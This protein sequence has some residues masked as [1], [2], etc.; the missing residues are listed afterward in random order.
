MEPRVKLWLERNGRIVMSEYRL[1]LLALVAE[2][3]SLAEAAEQMGLSYRRAWGKIKELERNLDLSLV[4]SAVGGV[5]GGHTTIT[6]E[7]RDLLR[8]FA[9]FQSQAEAAVRSAYEQAF[10]GDMGQGIPAS[11]GP[12]AEDSTQAG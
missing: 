6:S 1:R 9:E 12:A 11:T 8:R 5:G 10:R 4:E 2:T 3:G 7:G